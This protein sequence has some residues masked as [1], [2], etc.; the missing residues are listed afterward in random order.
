M[1]A[2]PGR[3]G[4]GSDRSAAGRENFRFLTSQR[5]SLRTY[6]VER[7][8]RELRRTMPVGD[9]AIRA[10]ATAEVLSAATNEPCQPS[11]VRTTAKRGL[12]QGGRVF[13]SRR[14][15]RYGWKNRICRATPM[16]WPGPEPGLPAGRSRAAP[17]RRSQRSRIEAAQRQPGATARSCAPA[18]RHHG[19]CRL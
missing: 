9:V 13:A 17:T 6:G 19:P 2:R 14:T 11:P 5:A 8:G 3:D 1:K 16:P 10:A 7:A 18:D 12:E 4:A 15:I